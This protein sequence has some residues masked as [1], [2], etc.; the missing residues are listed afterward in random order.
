MASTN[1]AR[2]ELL[3]EYGECECTPDMC[4]D[5][6]NGDGYCRPCARMDPY[7]ACFAE[8]SDEDEDGGQP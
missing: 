4:F 8:E 7:W 6:P 3:R 5:D 2:A 1:E